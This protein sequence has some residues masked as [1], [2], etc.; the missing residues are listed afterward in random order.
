MKDKIYK[1]IFYFYNIKR[2]FRLS[3]WTHQNYLTDIL[4]HTN[5]TVNFIQKNRDAVTVLVNPLF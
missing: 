4:D 2:I 1:K 5:R 3:S